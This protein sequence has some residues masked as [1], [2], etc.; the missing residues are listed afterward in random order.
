MKHDKWPWGTWIVVGWLI[1]VPL[2]TLYMYQKEVNGGFPFSFGSEFGTNSPLVWKGVLFAVVSFIIA[3]GL[4]PAFVIGRF[5]SKRW[6]LEN[7]FLWGIIGFYLT[8]VVIVLF[9]SF[10]RDVLIILAARLI[11]FHE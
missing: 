8:I 4:H 10:F 1:I 6:G 9:L 2:L 7:G 11:G 3:I 5:C